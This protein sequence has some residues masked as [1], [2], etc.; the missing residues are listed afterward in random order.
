MGEAGNEKNVGV[1]V[2]G[3]RPEAVSAAGTKQNPGK[4]NP[5]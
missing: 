3:N 4:P 2:M 5:T 1:R